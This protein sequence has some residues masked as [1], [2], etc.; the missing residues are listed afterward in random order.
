MLI[1]HPSLELELDLC[2]VGKIGGA[3]ARPDMLK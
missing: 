3:C 2:D 1:R